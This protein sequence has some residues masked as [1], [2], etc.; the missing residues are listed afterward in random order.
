MCVKYGFFAGALLSVTL[1]NC[2]PVTPPLPQK[3]DKP[4]LSFSGM[5]AV[6]DPVEGYHEAIHLSWSMPQTENTPVRSFT[7]VRKF[8][9]DSFYDVFSGS[10]LIPADTNNF[11]DE[12]AQH[13]FPASGF[14][15]VSYR[16]CAVDTF[17]RTGDTSEICMV[18]LAPQAK[19]VNYDTGNGCF[20]WESWIRGG[21]FSWCTAWHETG[22]PK[23]TCQQMDAFPETDKPGRFSACFPD[24]LQ[25]PLHGRWYYALFLKANET[26]SLKIGTIDVE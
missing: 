21:I 24:T 5:A 4:V 10:R 22:K 25:P 3:L 11:Y 16:L 23:W 20:E 8:S 15:S 1:L 14:D 13:P 7:L 6:P 18:I 12:L 17:G 19:F 9:T 2:L 26:H